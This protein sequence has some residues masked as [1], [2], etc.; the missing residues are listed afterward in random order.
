MKK[1]KIVDID[2]DK[3]KLILP[4]SV[5]DLLNQL[6]RLSFNS[7]TNIIIY[8]LKSFCKKYSYLVKPNK[9]DNSISNTTEVNSEE[10]EKYIEHI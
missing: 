7:K 10:L 5:N 6:S 3:V 1:E 8:I 4:H 2:S 9:V